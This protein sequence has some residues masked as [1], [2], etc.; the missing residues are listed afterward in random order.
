M[1]E[2][3]RA[4]GTIVVC[5]LLLLPVPAALV[6][7]ITKSG[8]D[9]AGARSRGSGGSSRGKSTSTSGERK[10]RSPCTG[11]GTR[12]RGRAAVGGDACGRSQE[13]RTG[14]G[15]CAV[16]GWEEADGAGSIVAADV[17][18]GG[19]ATGRSTQAGAGHGTAGA[20][21]GRWVW[22]TCYFVDCLLCWGVV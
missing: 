13:G 4:G 20:V 16:A 14:R 1:V 3:A 17:P 7:T 21:R 12:D 8:G 5:V 6:P 18:G 15:G 10:T 22:V 11:V 2:A 19:V 9:G